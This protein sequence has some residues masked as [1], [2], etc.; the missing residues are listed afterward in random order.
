MIEDPRP[1]TKDPRG[2]FCLG[3]CE[4]I[5][6]RLGNWVAKI[7]LLCWQ[8]RNLWISNWYQ[9]QA[10]PLKDRGISFR[11]FW[12]GSSIRWALISGIR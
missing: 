10:H 12:P 5:D 4:P 7:Q 2:I 3:S 8:D 11:C 6:N 1:K 9:D